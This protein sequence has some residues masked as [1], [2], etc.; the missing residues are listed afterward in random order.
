[1]VPSPKLLVID[2]DRSI[3]A[4]TRGILE[5]DWQSLHAKTGAEGLALLQSETVDAV[6]LDIMLPDLGGLEIYAKIREIDPRLPV[7]FITSEGGGDVVIEA[8]QLGAYDYVVKPLDVQHLKHLIQ[9]AF[10]LRAMVSVPVAI[11]AEPADNASQQLLIGSSPKMVE[12]FK[13]IGRVA[14][15]DIAVLIRGETGTG[16]ELVARAIVQHSGRCDGPFLAVNCAAITETLLESELFGHEKGAFTG[17]DSRRIG[18][19]EQ[20]KGGTLFLDEV[21]DMAI[22]VQ[23]KLLR[24]LQERTFERVG[25]NQVLTTDV[26][27]IAA[28]NRPLEAMGAE[29]TFRGD[30]LYRLDGVTIYLPPLRERRAD[31]PSLLQHFLNRAKQDFKLENLE[32]ISAEATHMLCDYAWPGNVRQLQS[33]VRRMVIDNSAGVLVPDNVPLDIRGE[34]SSPNSDASRPREAITVQPSAKPQTAISPN[35]Y[36]PESLVSRLLRE[37]STDVYAQVLAQMERHLFVRVLQAT[38]GN[39][40]QAAEI[41]GITR[42]KVRD[43]I[44]AYGISLEGKVS[45]SDSQEVHHE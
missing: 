42:G 44:T 40:S 3:H 4:I 1:V 14:K 28:T 23:A 15:Q 34:L 45:M 35:G 32:G 9:K 19:F 31:I 16:K 2:D 43:R 20:A 33:V 38:G 29:G 17:A 8:M 27:I 12:V 30:L 10:A 37:K 24:V 41:L 11:G 13:A 7:I 25:G 39:Q 21:G 22:G 26:R 18:K 5:E 6:L 36:D